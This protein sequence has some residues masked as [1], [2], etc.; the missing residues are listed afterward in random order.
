MYSTSRRYYYYLVTLVTDYVIQE[1]T[2]LTSIKNI[3]KYTCEY[4]RM[5]LNWCEMIHNYKKKKFILIAHIIF[6]HACIVYIYI[7][8]C[9]Y[10]NKTKANIRNKTK[11]DNNWIEAN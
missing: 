3:V 10:L 11:T 1:N 4:I 6:R 7:I 8:I 9:F 5:H 2:A